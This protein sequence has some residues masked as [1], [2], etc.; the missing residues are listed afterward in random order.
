MKKLLR[1][2]NSKA[3]IKVKEYKNLRQNVKCGNTQT[4]SMKIGESL[5]LKI[6]I[7]FLL[8]I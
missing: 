3:T 4:R 1:I 5:I 6:E 8:S 2:H 7:L